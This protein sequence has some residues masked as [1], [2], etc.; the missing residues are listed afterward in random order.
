MLQLITPVIL[1]FNEEANIER[2]LKALHW[3]D[4]IVIVDSYSTDRTIEIISNFPKARIVQRRFDAHANQWNF[5]IGETDIGT[6]WILALDADYLLTDE[7]VSELAGLDPGGACSAYAADFTYC[8]MG[9]PL[10][11]TLYPAAT[12][13]FRRRGARY[14]QTGHTQRLEIDGLVRRLDAKILHDDRKPLSRW[15]TSQRNY[16]HL[17]AEHLLNSPRTALRATDR[18]RSMAWPAP[19]LVFIYVLLVK[20][21]ILDGWPGWLYV[22]QRTLAEIMIAMEIVDRSLRLD[23]QRK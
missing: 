13:L 1:T 17:E 20:G 22:L 7:F 18:V 2:T 5:A 23:A 6:E 21:C 15:L 8:V 19:V 16:A 14:V 3:A 4:D 10:R 11:G 12:L 9:R